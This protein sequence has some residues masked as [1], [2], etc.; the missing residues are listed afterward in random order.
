MAPADASKKEG[1][2][3]SKEPKLAAVTIKFYQIK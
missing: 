3:G 1:D 2:A